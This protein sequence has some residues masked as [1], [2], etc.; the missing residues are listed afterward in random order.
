M[1][2]WLDSVAPRY[3]PSAGGWS[4]SAFSLRTLY[5]EHLRLNNW[6]THTNDNYPLIQYLGCTITLYKSINVDYLFSYQSHY[7]MRASALMYHSTHPAVQLLNNRKRLI[8]CKHNNNKKKNWK[9]IRIPPPS[10]MYNRWYFQRDI[11]DVPLLLTTATAASIDR[12]FLHSNSPSTTI[13]FASLNSLTFT[14]HH[15]T[16]FTPHIPYQPQVNQYLFAT[17]NGATDINKIKFGELIFLGNS[18]KMQLGT[19]IQDYVSPIATDNDQKTIEKYFQD[20]NLWGNPFIAQYFTGDKRMIITTLT[21]QQIKQTYTSKTQTLKSTEFAFKTTSNIIECRYNP[22]PDT[23]LGNKIYLL[24]ITRVAGSN[25]WQPD[26]EE[27]TVLTKDLPLWVGC[28]GFLDWQKKLATYQE[29]DT[30]CILVIQSTF[31]EPK[32]EPFYIPLDREFLDNTSPYRPT[33]EVTPSDKENW[34]PKVLFQV[35]SINNFGASG[36]A[37]AKLGRDQ[38]CEAHIDYKFK[39]KLGGSPAPMS[40]LTNPGEQPKYNTPDNLLRTT[41]LQ[42]PA[43]PFEH[44]LYSFDERRGQITD[45]AAKRLKKD[46][47]F[48]KTLLPFAGTS[49]TDLP[50]PYQGPPTSETSDS[51]EAQ[52]PEEQL[53]Q[54]Y[55]QQK[56]LT[57][58]IKQ[59]LKKMSNIE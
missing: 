29:I 27:P 19:L 40:G 12:M 1:N 57:K 59:L 55:L 43:L 52:T 46:S 6:W 34:H 56:L 8:T 4:L 5:N 18:N 23:G 41:S 32:A 50:A 28:W 58:R 45:K 51:E 2:T 44:I 36:P 25:S 17:S 7:P 38:S 37:T 26:P 16:N 47:D 15:F 21:L 54:Q 14:N 20:E 9:K 13:G 35:K 10:Q 53:Q 42:S 49:T 11:V 22:L 3:I 30:K 31:I 33:H 39:F 24:K 48:E